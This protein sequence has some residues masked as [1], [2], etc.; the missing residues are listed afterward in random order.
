MAR[1]RAGF[2]LELPEPYELG[3]E[4]LDVYRNFV[5]PSTV[6]QRVW[7]RAWELDPGAPQVV[8]HAI[9]SVD[10]G[11]WAAAQDA[12]D[13]GPGF[14]AMDLRGGASPGGF[15]LVWAPGTTPG[16]GADT[17]AAWNL[18]PTTSLILQVHLQPSG[19]PESVRPRVG[20]Y[21]TAEPPSRQGLTLRVGDEPID[22][23]PGQT[24]FEMRDQIS[25]AADATLTSVFPHAHY[26]ARSV[27]SQAHLP[28]GSTRWLLDIDDWDFAWQ[29]QYRYADGGIELP[30]GTVIDLVIRYD[31]SADN[32]RNP[33]SPP[34]RVVT[35]P[36]ST[37]EMGNL[38]F[39]LLAHDQPGLLSLR[40]G[41]YRRALKF[42][43]SADG[44]YNLA[45]TLRDLGRL[46]DAEA[47]YR[48]ALVAEP[49]HPWSL[50]NLA[51]LLMKLRRFDDAVAVAQRE[52][53][54]APTSA[55]AHNNLGNAL[56]GAERPADAAVE[57]RA[58][59][60]L[61]PNFEM[62]RNNL[63]AMGLPERE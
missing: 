5:L 60:A 35:G 15:Y 7:V 38:T 42:D 13:P 27:Q 34:Q 49:S 48:A 43:G 25:L 6:G 32:P 51:L 28:D 17:N 59:L 54:V 58:A 39:E 24:D 45:N 10:R 2:I 14:T 1:R 29:D 44:H 8:H 19:K 4:G 57:F 20:L 23:A 47:E 36:N 21:L 30:A 22:I 31:N 63:R 46:E 3:A 40:E 55:A 62:A 33:H 16:T 26:L 18:D 50:H 9:L 61:D 11:G 53:A 52:I 56:R 12:A 41:K 37:D